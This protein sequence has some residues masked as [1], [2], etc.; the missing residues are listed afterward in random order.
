[1]LVSKMAMIYLSFKPWNRS[2]LS[3]KRERPEAWS[4]WCSA[5]LAAALRA[6][7][8]WPRPRGDD[9]RWTMDDGDTP[10]AGL[11]P[12]IHRPSSIVLDRDSILF[13]HSRPSLR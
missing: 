8:L 9:G 6:F 12:I 1:M 2:R 7:A 11:A 13:S 10:G 3:A 5:N 4:P